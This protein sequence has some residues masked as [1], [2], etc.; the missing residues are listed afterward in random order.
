MT[1]VTDQ[2]AVAEWA[3]SHKI[4]D[5]CVKI[6]LKE[7]FTSMEAISLFEKEELGPKIPR[8]KTG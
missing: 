2:D 3:K 1:A 7:E 4:S 5:E 8:S 6:L